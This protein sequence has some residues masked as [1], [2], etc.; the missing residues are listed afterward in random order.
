M[1]KGRFKLKPL[2]GLRHTYTGFHRNKIWARFDD[3]ITDIGFW[4]K[5]N[6]ETISLFFSYSFWGVV[7]PLV[8][9]YFVIKV[10]LQKS[11]IAAALTALI[12]AGIVYQVGFW[13]ACL[14]GLCIEAICFIFRVIFKN[15]IC[16]LALLAIG[17]GITLYFL[18]IN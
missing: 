4:F 12:G 11:L 10:W 8:L 17:L 2:V 1:K 7:G 9:V 15:A 6:T 18:F 5:D 3:S 13:I 16:F 14:L